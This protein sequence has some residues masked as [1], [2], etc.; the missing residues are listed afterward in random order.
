MQN[1]LRGPKCL[2]RKQLPFG[3]LCCVS[4]RARV[5][6]W[7]EISPN[8]DLFFKLAKLLF[9]SGQIPKKESKF[10]QQKRQIPF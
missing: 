7:G 1:L 2:V 9:L 5:L 8:G 3:V 6:F 10:F 4:V